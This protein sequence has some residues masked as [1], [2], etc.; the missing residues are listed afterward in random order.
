M[1]QD[2][3]QSTTGSTDEV[4]KVASKV[5]E[6][7]LVAFRRWLEVGGCKMHS[8]VC[9]VNGEVTD[10][11]K[12]APLLSFG[13]PIASSS[14]TT[15]SSSRNSS[16]DATSSSSSNSNTSGNSNKTTSPSEGRCGMIDSDVERAFYDRTYGCQ[17][18]VSKEMREDQ[19][20]MTIPQSIMIT[21]DLIASSDAGRAVLACCQEMDVDASGGTNGNMNYW[22]A[23]CSMTEKERKILQS[24]RNTSG[25]QLLVKIL[26]ERKKADMIIA[27]SIKTVEAAMKE[28][29]K[30]DYTLAKKG[31]ISTRAAY[32]LYFIQQRFAN[33]VNPSVTVGQDFEI[34]S[35]P[36]KK[37]AGSSYPPPPLSSD[38]PTTFA[39]Y[40]R[41][42]P[43]LI[44]IPLCWKRNEYAL[45][46]NCPS[47]VP[48]LQE[49]YSQMMALTSDLIILLDAGLLYRFP[50]LV[51]KDMLTFDR[52]VWAASIF[53]SRMLPSSYYFNMGSSGEGGETM[54]YSPQS[55][56]QEMGVFVPFMDMLNHDAQSNQ[57]MWDA[58][59]MMVDGDGVAQGKIMLKRRIKKTSEVFTNYGAYSN[60]DMMLRYG[61]VKINN[62]HDT[63]PISWGLSNCVGKVPAPAD[64]VDLEMKDGN[65]MAVNTS[66]VD[67]SSVY[68]SSD[69]DAIN[70]WWT[71]D[72]LSLLERTIRSNDTFWENLKKGNKMTVMAH[73]DGTINPILLRSV[74]VATMS[75]SNVEKHAKEDAKKEPLKITKQHQQRIRKYLIFLFSTKYEKVM[76]GFN[77][78][79]KNHYNSVKLWTK[80]TEGAIDYKNPNAT[81]KGEEDI[82]NGPVSWRFFFDYHA[83][84]GSMEIEKHFYALVPESCVLT[85]YDGHL[86]SLYGSLEKVLSSSTFDEKVLGEIERLGFVISDDIEDISMEESKNVP[87][88]TAVE[89]SKKES[90]SGGGKSEGKDGKG[91][92]KRDESKR[93]DQPKQDKDNASKNEGNRE[94]NRNRRNR[95]RGG[96]GGNGGGGGGNGPP[97][98]KLHIGNLS[99]KTPPI[100]LFD[101]FARRYGRQS[102]IECHIPT[103]RESGKS[104]GFG[105]VTMPESAAM[106]VLQSNMPH[107]IDGRVVKIAES[108][109]T[110][111]NRGNATN[112][113]PP[114]QDRGFHAMGMPMM[115]AMPPGPPGPYGPPPDDMYGPIPPNNGMDM[116]DQHGIHWRGNMEPPPRNGGR[117]RSRSRNR[118][119][120]YSRSPSPRYRKD[121][122]Y[123]DRR[124]RVR[125]S[126]SRSRSLSHSRDRRD[127]DRRR[128]RRRRSRY[129]SSR[130]RSDSRSISR[131]RSR[132]RTRS[133]SRS[134]SYSPPSSS[135]RRDRDRERDRERKSANANMNNNMEGSGSGGKSQS[136][137]EGGGRSR[138]RSPSMSISPPREGKSETKKREGVK[139]RHRSRSRDRDRRGRKRS[140]K[141][142]RK[143]RSKDR[144]KRHESMSRSQ[145]R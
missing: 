64:Y 61:F 25:P 144:V 98:L 135:R 130:Y 22:D 95:K 69:H 49:V 101:Y 3:I 57:V 122:R 141:S 78:G 23:F 5:L 14:D 70:A 41:T 62:D 15:R 107:E 83:Y 48:V 85:L 137:S 131:S 87:K 20:M 31:S 7:R 28:G 92:S 27:K 91:S 96:G 51:S 16:S 99:Y 126:Y 32:L 56:W 133:R 89:E 71:K 100:E 50:S 72:R 143:I 10:G 136:R 77:D 90:S 76:T 24:V 127:R 45:L 109:T 43:P 120:S 134:P 6:D 63:V 145:S 142:S 39:P 81:G 40:L 54:C 118:N 119:R 104:R 44:P 113:Y 139:R 93:S 75:P 38:A 18:R 97:S 30:P 29:T 117:R 94:R 66:V 73:G 2:K 26:Q 103:E 125:R 4:N 79:L 80:A 128:D 1:E 110:S 42:L 67:P 52:W 21:P 34:L 55:V 86:R 111:G 106:Q 116:H 8:S 123:Y 124:D 88:Q 12:N 60:Q 19:V 65:V 11:T 37:D 36:I 129:R 82:K 132:S 46:A 35:N 13:P 17:I 112:T 114:P 33:E 53:T 105:F 108:N 121:D 74:V 59:A 102:V 138:S 47:G 115:S 9:I 68:E 84:L 140:S 58:D